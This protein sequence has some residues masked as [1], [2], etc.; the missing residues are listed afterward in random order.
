MVAKTSVRF[1]MVAIECVNIMRFGYQSSHGT[2]EK[3]SRE[4]GREGGG[5]VD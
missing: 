3:V 2:R 5:W 1:V 4:G